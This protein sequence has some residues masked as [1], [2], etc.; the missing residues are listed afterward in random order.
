MKLNKVLYSILFAALA[1]FVLWDSSVNYGYGF[2]VA[3]LYLAGI[4]LI[5]INVTLTM[6]GGFIPA[7]IASKKDPVEAL[8]TE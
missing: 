2:L 7:R 5:V 8:R 4:I 6:L 3:F 1:D